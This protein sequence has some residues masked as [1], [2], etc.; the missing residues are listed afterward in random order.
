[1]TRRAEFAAFGLRASRGV[2]MHG[3]PGCSKPLLARACASEAKC[4]FISLSGA[5]VYSPY[6]GEAEATVRRAFE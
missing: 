2:L 4:A 6:L 1:M 3:P 5:D